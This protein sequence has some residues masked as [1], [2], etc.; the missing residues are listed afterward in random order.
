MFWWDL[1]HFICGLINRSSRWPQSIS[2]PR[3]ILHGARKS[4]NHTGV[5]KITD[6][7]EAILTDSSE[8]RYTPPKRHAHRISANSNAAASTLVVV[9][10]SNENCP[11]NNETS[12]KVLTAFT[13]CKCLATPMFFGLSRASMKC[14]NKCLFSLY[15]CGF[16]YNLWTGVTNLNRSHNGK[17]LAHTPTRNKSNGVAKGSRPCE[18]ASRRMRTTKRNKNGSRS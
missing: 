15:S 18:V 17:K 9:H 7:C 12:T 1:I 16:G 11:S 3:W 13:E 2:A 14:I 10:I 8:N 6:G 4:V 5:G